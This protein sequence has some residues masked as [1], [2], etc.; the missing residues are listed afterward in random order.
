MV[1]NDV[2]VSCDCDCGFDRGPVRCMAG[3]AHVVS[4]LPP[5][6][7]P[8]DSLGLASPRGNTQSCLLVAPIVLSG[9][10][11]VEG[12]PVAL[13]FPLTMQTLQ[14][15]R[16]GLLFICAVA[17]AHA[18]GCPEY[19][20]LRLLV[21][22]FAVL[23]H[24]GD[25]VQWSRSGGMGGRRALRKGMGRWGWKGGWVEGEGWRDAKGEGRWVKRF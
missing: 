3:T 20:A 12:L 19:V 2:S 21:Q 10:P 1:P 7:S 13:C 17:I 14:S 11:H 8:S 4:R 25:R 18:A 5:P 6:A 22:L 15:H 23:L 9:R 24:T 16:V